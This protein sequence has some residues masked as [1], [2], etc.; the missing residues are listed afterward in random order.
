MIGAFPYQTAQAMVYADPTRTGPGHCRAQPIGY[1]D[2]MR[3]GGQVTGV[4][5]LQGMLTIWAP[6]PG[7]RRAQHGQRPLRV[8]DEPAEAVRAAA[9]RPRGRGRRGR[10]Q[11]PRARLLRR[12]RVL[13]LRQRRRALRPGTPQLALPAAWFTQ[14]HCLPG[15]QSCATYSVRSPGTYFV[16]GFVLLRQQMPDRPVLICHS[17]RLRVRRRS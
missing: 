2:P 15:C 17:V 10:A 5:K 3:T 11:G 12:R 6:G 13:P 16:A 7:H 9:A 8:R 4:L 14:L 1:A